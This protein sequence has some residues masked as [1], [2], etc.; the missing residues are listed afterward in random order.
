MT[1]HKLL[2]KEL[3]KLR[4]YHS[5]LP[6]LI[7]CSNVYGDKFYTINDLHRVENEIN[8]LKAKLIQN[9]S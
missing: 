4:R 9:Q 5:I 8:K 6:R 1:E 3:S 2:K 7:D